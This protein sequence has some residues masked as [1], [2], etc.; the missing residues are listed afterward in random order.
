MTTIVIKDHMG[1]KK[2]AIKAGMLLSEV[3][4]SLLDNNTIGA[5]VVDEAL[6]V[7]G[8]VSEQDCIR[9]LLLS[10][11]HSEG[12]PRVE[13]VMFEAP[14]TVAPNDS[15]ITLAEEMI[16]HKPKIYP[17]V[18]EGKLIGI[19]SRADVLRA[20]R[21]HEKSHKTWTKANPD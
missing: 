4:D 1:S 7:V 12:M 11:Y 9:Q 19:I 16:L 20:L 8:F 18:D 15:I 6:H 2:A 13:E 17:V 3:V 5:P 21:Q 14:L 10:S